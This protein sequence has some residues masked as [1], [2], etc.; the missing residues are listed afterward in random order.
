MLSCVLAWIRKKDWNFLLILIVLNTKF[1]ILIVELNFSL[2]CHCQ[3][4][5]KV[6]YARLRGRKRTEQTRSHSPTTRPRSPSSSTCS[7]RE[8]GGRPLSDTSSSGSLQRP[9][10]PSRNS[11]LMQSLRRQESISANN[12]VLLLMLLSIQC[13]F[14]ISSKLLLFAF[15]M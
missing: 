11:A 13:T 10:R 7:T 3:Q 14:C 15:W 1:K 4:T 2:M 5:L 6:E 12:D 9:S 8:C